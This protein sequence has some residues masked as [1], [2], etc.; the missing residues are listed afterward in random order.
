MK[1]YLGIDVSK[2]YADFVLLSDQLVKQEE[3]FQLDD[4]KAGHQLLESWLESI[5]IRHPGLLID[6]AVES[7]GGFENNWHAFLVRLSSHMAI[8]V[9]RLNPSVVKHASK[10]LLNANKTDAESARE[11]AIYL[12]RYEDQ[13]DYGVQ[14]TQYAGFRSL[15]G[16]LELLT[17]QKTQ[18]INE[19]KQLLYSSFPELQ[20]FCKQSV[21]GWMLELLKKYPSPEKLS[22]VKPETLARIQGITI[23]KAQA[24][25]ERAKETI[26]CRNNPA[27][28]FLIAQMAEEVML[29]QEKVKALKKYLAEQCN[30][31]ETA[32]L[33]TIKGVGAY[34][35]AAI[36]IQIE[37]IGRF[38]SPKELA[39][40]FG[41]H[42]VLKM[43]GDSKMVSRMS[44]QGRSAIRGVLYMCASSAARSDNHMHSIYKRHRANGKTHKQVIGIIMHKLL[45]VIW[46]VL[47]SQ[48]PYDPAIDK[49]NQEARPTTPGR[50]EAA[51]TANKRRLQGFD[52]NAPVSRKAS[53]KRKV[54]ATSQAGNAG[55][56]R[57]LVHEPS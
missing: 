13:V 6:C 56:M 25:V 44:K 43:S 3:T 20:R 14:D 36:M 53:K 9:A 2:G 35:A 52:E 32:L 23:K 17:R 33:E 51:E 39:S 41:L 54:H 26:G 15:Y 24:L 10:A 37:S 5:F 16:H 29:K 1:W 21:P 45:R 30:G 22:R 28:A 49:A 8:R 31:K 40:Y 57:D 11:I 46:G 34:S 38:N 47:Q 19:L 18:I 12:K 55:L 50:D 27:E 42:P 48:K 7:T 4:T